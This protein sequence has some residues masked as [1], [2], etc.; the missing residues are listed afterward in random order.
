MLSFSDFKGL[1]NF[2]GIYQFRSPRVL[3]LDPKLSKDILTGKFSNFHDNEISHMFEMK[4]D[5]LFARNPFLS[6]GMEWKQNRMEISAAFS[7]NRTRIYYSL[8]EKICQ[9]LVTFIGQENNRA[10]EVKDLA[11]K[12]TLEN[13]S[14]SIFQ[15]ESNILQ[16]NESELRKMARKLAK[17]SII[18]IIKV[19]II[20]LIPMMKHF[21]KIIVVSDEVNEY[22][23]NFL[24]QS[25]EHRENFETS[26]ADFLDFLVNLKK[27]KNMRTSEVAGHAI[28]LFSDGLESSALLLTHALYEIAK[29]DKIQEKL[30]DEIENFAENKQD[31]SEI[32]H[33]LPYL[34]QVVNGKNIVF[35]QNHLFIFFQ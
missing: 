22:F 29:N 16:K 11:E 18:N 24:K 9:R 23:F 26:R 27:K 7:S 30:R 19:V 32:P 20:T 10:I 13:V 28:P 1:A 12:F 14:S 3:I 31:S 6:R 8:V 21:L 2:V 35:H 5:P 25:V 33:N 4:N 17:M 15:I 34:D